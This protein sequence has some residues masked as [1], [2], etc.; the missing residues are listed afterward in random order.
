MPVQGPISQ[1][2]TG[3]W[4]SHS[5]RQCV[6]HVW[7]VPFFSRVFCAPCF[8]WTLRTPQA[9]QANCCRAPTRTKARGSLR[10]ATFFPGVPSSTLRHVCLAPNTLCRQLQGRPRSTRV[11]LSRRPHRSTR[12]VLS[13]RPHR[14]LRSSPP[15]SP[16]DLA[17]LLPP[18]PLWRSRSGSSPGMTV[19]GLKT[20]T[21]V[22]SRR[23][24][25]SLRSSPPLSPRDLALLLP[26]LPLWRSRSGSSP[27][28]TLTGLKTVTEMLRNA[29][30]LLR[31]WTSRWTMLTGMKGRRPAAPRRCSMMMHGSHCAPKAA[32]H[33]RN[34]GGT[35]GP[36][37]TT[38]TT[39][40][41]TAV[42]GGAGGGPAR[43]L[44]SRREP[45]DAVTDC[46]TMCSSAQ[47][48]AVATRLHC[49]KSVVP[50]A[51]GISQEWA[52]SSQ[53]V[54]CS[55]LPSLGHQRVL[56]TCQWPGGA[57]GNH[58]VLCGNHG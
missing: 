29:V 54:G 16:R 31:R 25:R 26:P 38:R 57:V 1:Y 50:Q 40:V 17:L 46:K 43:A 5:I 44:P 58:G 52:S 20:V 18:L 33:I 19:T 30:P 41:A 55:Q 53:S 21:V 49:K 34:T 51:S 2:C 47:P 8:L 10:S 48:C 3:R 32:A 14:S 56:F 9:P 7:V 27:G 12:V 42:S 28:M 45:A 11:V 15:L 4:P 37:A 6:P 24:H 39:A 23:P 36:S 13:R 22:L 35:C